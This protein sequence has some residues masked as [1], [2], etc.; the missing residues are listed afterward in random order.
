MKN[1]LV[2]IVIP[3]K[4]RYFYLQ[5]IIESILSFDSDLLEIIIQDNSEDNSE[6]YSYIKKNN[7]SRLRYYHISDWLSVSDN[8]EEGIKNASGE[9][10]CMIGDDD[11]ITP[12]I[13]DLAIWMKKHNIDAALPN[14]PSY[15]WPGITTI[16]NGFDEGGT[17]FLPKY[18]GEIKKIN[19]EKELLSVLNT[20]GTQLLQLPRV[21]H[22]LVSKKCLDNLRKISGS[23]FPGPSPDMANA[24]GLCAVINSFVIVDIPIA[25]SGNCRES[26]GGQ[27]AVHAHH[28]ELIDKKFLPKDIIESWPLIVPHFWSGSTIWAASVI[29][30]LQK[31]QQHKYLD[32]IKLNRL[33]AM[34]LVFHPEYMSR[35]SES[36]QHNNLNNIVD[37]LSINFSKIWVWSLRTQSLLKN[38]K[39]KVL[40]K[41]DLGEK[42]INMKNINN[43]IKYITT[44]KNLIKTAKKSWESQ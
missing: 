23:C 8:C 6:F 1:I 29:L 33:Y 18:T 4:N 38:I 41:N 32:K 19:V 21:Y 40:K 20:G 24:I 26:A 7:D 25:I 17:L 36:I 10:I 39:F 15:H 9:F 2:S 3:T 12:W 16:L 43:A 13:I 31:S 42:I 27:N 44:D 35:I 11:G 5:S 28:G 34:C 37:I 30:A 14:K 22:G